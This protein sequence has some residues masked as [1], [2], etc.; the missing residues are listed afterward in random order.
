MHVMFKLLL[1]QVDAPPTTA[2]T[3]LSSRSGPLLRLTVSD[4]ELSTYEL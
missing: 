4:M 1:L 3:S 2:C